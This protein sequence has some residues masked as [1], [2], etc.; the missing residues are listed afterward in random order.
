MYK[1]ISKIG[2]LAAFVV[3]VAMSGCLEGYKPKTQEELLADFLK[4]VDQTKLASDIALI[5]DSLTKWSL[6]AQNE[7]NGVRYIVHELGTGPMPTLRSLVTLEYTGKFFTTKAIFDENPN[8]QLFVGEFI[9]AW[10][11]TLPLLPEGTRATLYAPSGLAYGPNGAR[12]PNTGTLVIPAH[13]NL[14]FDIY[15]K[16]VQ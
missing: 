8:V 15:L 14:I 4:N 7:P 13:A 3:V 16:D 5:E 2:L 6:V 1:L 11:L 9:P 10:Q 12:D